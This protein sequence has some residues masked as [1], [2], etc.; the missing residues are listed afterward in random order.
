MII[1]SAQ[2]TDHIGFDEID[3]DEL[4]YNYEYGDYEGSGLMIARIGDKY[5]LYDMSHCSCYG[6][7]YH[8]KFNGRLWED[9]I[10]NLKINK[11][12]WT[13]SILDLIVS[14][15]INNYNSNPI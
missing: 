7:L 6:P 11:E 9:F 1:H 10:S 4:W 13:G 8:F 5:D 15:N 3:V 2:T 12:Y 14:Y